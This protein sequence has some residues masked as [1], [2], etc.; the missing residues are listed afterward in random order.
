MLLDDIW[1]FI[2][3]ILMLGCL[4]PV[5]HFYLLG[6]CFICNELHGAYAIVHV[7]KSL[8]NLPPVFNS[9]WSS[10]KIVKFNRIISSC[11][12]S[13]FL[14]RILCFLYFWSEYHVWVSCLEWKAFERVQYQSLWESCALLSIRWVE[15]HLARGVPY[16][17]SYRSSHGNLLGS[18]T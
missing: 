14:H 5:I 1:M 10:W 6:L 11:A 16:L 12:C 3:F 13:V 4:E 18:L 2:L 17:P 8:Q 9:R 7:L 15:V